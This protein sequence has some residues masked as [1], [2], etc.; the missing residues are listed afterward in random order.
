MGQAGLDYEYGIY[1]HKNKVAWIN[2][3]FPAGTNDKT[4]YRSKLKAAVEKKQKQHK[5]K[6]KVIADDG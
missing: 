1:T 5:N 4:V 3:P 2:G 6:F